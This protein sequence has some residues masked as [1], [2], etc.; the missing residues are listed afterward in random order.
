MYSENFDAKLD[1]LLEQIAV[2]IDEKEQLRAKNKIMGEQVD[3]L[4]QMVANYEIMVAK[5]QKMLDKYSELNREN[6][7][8]FD[9]LLDEK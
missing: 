2:L 5:Q 9:E 1:E 3:L 7:T 8:M 6:I 4:K